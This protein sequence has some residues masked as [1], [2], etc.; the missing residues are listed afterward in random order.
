MNKRNGFARKWNFRARRSC[1]RCV[2]E[3]GEHK[4]RSS[5]EESR[6]KKKSF[7]EFR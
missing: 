5:T 3:N 6:A 2:A 1:G 7:A 4:N